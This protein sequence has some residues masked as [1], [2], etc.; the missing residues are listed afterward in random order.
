VNHPV[1]IRT[2]DHKVSLGVGGPYFAITERLR[3]MHFDEVMSESAVAPFEI[4]A[5]A[6]AIE[7]MQLDR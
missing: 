6:H 4:E 1:A 5:A 2:K 3:M 7:A